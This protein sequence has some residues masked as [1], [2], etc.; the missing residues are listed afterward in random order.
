MTTSDPLARKE[1]Q[2][3]LR[4]IR[5]NPGRMGVDPVFPVRHRGF[6]RTLEKAGL[7]RFDN[8]WYANEKGEENGTEGRRGT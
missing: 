3:L 2:Y 7:I 1:A 5:E 4:L 6:F 8:G